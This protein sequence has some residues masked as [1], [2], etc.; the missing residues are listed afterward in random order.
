MHVA[1]HFKILQPKG[2]SL[3][4]EIL[5]RDGGMV[6]T[7]VIPFR[8]PVPLY[9]GKKFSAYQYE[10][11]IMQIM[12]DF[13]YKMTNFRLMFQPRILIR[14]PTYRLRLIGSYLN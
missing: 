12:R 13:V 10:D 7:R 3:C 11:K 9:Q 4:Y 5:I 14:I 1:Y 2:N 6:P 8:R